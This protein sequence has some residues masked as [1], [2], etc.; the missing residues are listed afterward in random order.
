MHA[1]LMVSFFESF[2]S[3]A[4]LQAAIGVIHTFGGIVPII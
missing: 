3:S 1:L 4:S 2:I